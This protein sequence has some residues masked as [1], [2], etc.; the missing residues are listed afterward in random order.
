MVGCFRCF[1]ID[2]TNPPTDMT[3]Q[4]SLAAVGKKYNT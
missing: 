4:N 2:D 1:S 3:E